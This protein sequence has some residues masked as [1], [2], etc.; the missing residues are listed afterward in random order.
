MVASIQLALVVFSL[1][2]VQTL[3]IKCYWAYGKPLNRTSS[4]KKEGGSSESIEYSSQTIRPSAPLCRRRQHVIRHV[5]T[6]INRI[7]RLSGNGDGH[8]MQH[9]NKC[10]RTQ[11]HISI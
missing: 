2:I 7:K 5:T 1:I 3:S 11:K 6:K 9:A 8:R 10:V 4:S